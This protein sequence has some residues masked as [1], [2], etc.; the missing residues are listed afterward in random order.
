MSFAWDRARWRGPVENL[1]RTGG[2]K[3]VAPIMRQ[4]V[5][6]VGPLG[7]DPNVLAGH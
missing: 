7:L 5:W 4:T 6:V 3:A 1:N 2:I